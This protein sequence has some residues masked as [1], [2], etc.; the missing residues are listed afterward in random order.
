M[1]DIKVVFAELLGLSAAVVDKAIEEKNL[2]QLITG[3]KVF[4][5]GEYDKLLDNVGKQAIDILKDTKKELP[6]E[7]YNRVR[8]TVLETE[9]NRLKKKFGYSGEYKGM[10]E[11]VENIVS[12]QVETVKNDSELTKEN[13]RLKDLVKKND[14]EWERKLTEAKSE[15]GN[16]IISESLTK[17]I[18]GIP[19]DAPDDTLEELRS[20]IINNF[21]SN[22][23]VKYENGKIIVS[24]KNGKQFTDKVGDPLQLADVVKETLPKFVKL[25]AI[26]GGRATDT[27]VVKG[28]GLGTIQN[29]ADLDKYFSD[30]KIAGNSMKAQE[31]IAEVVKLNPDFKF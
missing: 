8:G 7:I 27:Q 25:K 31:V 22:S 2:P 29:K 10:Q 21:K 5:T 1:D 24:D 20:V 13:Q 15:T 26:T 28:N 12:A 16:Y 18:S 4:T 14:E 9:E 30:N 3:Y 6:P 23:Q 11:L 19:I 17:A